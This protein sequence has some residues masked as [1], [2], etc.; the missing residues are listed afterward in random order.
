MAG[1]G[2]PEYPAASVPVLPT[3]SD[4]G[5]AAYSGGAGVSAGRCGEGVPV[6]CL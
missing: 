2:G 4:D 5:Q 6:L 3:V 1:V